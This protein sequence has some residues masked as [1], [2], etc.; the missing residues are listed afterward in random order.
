MG[1][2]NGKFPDGHPIDDLVREHLEEQAEQE[3][4]AALTAR[5]LASI[6]DTRLP[7]SPR[8]NR[9]LPHRTSG[10]SRDVS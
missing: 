8:H 3:D 2:M 5:V 10:R 4:T 1:E 6:S 9:Q 7:S